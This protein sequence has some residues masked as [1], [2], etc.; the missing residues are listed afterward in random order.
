MSRQGG[1]LYDRHITIFSPEG[2]LFQVEYAFRAVRASNLTAIALKGT[3]AA[4]IV[5]QKKLPTMQASQQDQLLDSSCITSLYN[6]SDHVGSCMVGMSGDCRAMSL[7]SRQIASE[8]AFDMGYSM[9]VHYLCHKVANLNQLYSQHAY[10][11]LHACTG[12]YIAMDDEK[13][14]SIYRFDPAG[15]FAG[16]KACA[17]GG[18]EQEATNALEKL[19]KK[20]ERV[21]E[22]EVVLDAIASLQE[23]LS[24]DFRPSDVEVGIVSLKHKAFRC[25]SESEIE[26][27][28]NEIADGD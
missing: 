19:V 18:K 8:F 25:L 24:A 16:Y 13:G 3:E 5:V 26:V 11:R 7:R 2:K 23:V 14:P 22:K 15:W 20:T 6:I 12:I 17:I 28:L 4:C 9:P 27:Y 10:M 1:S 21:N